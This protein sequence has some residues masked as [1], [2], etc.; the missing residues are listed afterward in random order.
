MSEIKSTGSAFEEIAKTEKTLEGTIK[1]LKENFEKAELNFRT[2]RNSIIE[3]LVADQKK[4][5]ESLRQI[6]LALENILARTQV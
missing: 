2:N 5:A 6:G 4:E 1:V 3:A